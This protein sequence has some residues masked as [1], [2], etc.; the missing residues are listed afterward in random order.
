MIR[1]IA[2]FDITLCVFASSRK[3][4]VIME[5]HRFDSIAKQLGADSSRRSVLKGL[6]G[7]GGIAVAGIAVN[8]QTEAARRGFS[9]PKIPSPTPTPIPTPTCIATG[10]PCDILNPAPCCSQCCRRVGTTETF[11]C[12]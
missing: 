4:V 3:G 8:D 6:L 10:D 9:G 7:I 12:C 2:P 11:V 1:P 5:D